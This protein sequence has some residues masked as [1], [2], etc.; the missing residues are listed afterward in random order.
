MRREDRG[1]ERREEE[2]GERRDDISSPP[3]F[4]LPVYPICTKFGMRV[5]CIDTQDSFFYSHNSRLNSVL[6]RLLD[7]KVMFFS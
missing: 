2:R 7:L 1:E 6:N 3:I 4:S 5:P